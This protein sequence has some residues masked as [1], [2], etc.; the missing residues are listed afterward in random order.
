MLIWQQVHV[1]FSLACA[2]IIHLSESSHQICKLVAICIL[3]L[4][5]ERQVLESSSKIFEK[6]SN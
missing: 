3:V 2:S 4:G 1:F 5:S 6:N